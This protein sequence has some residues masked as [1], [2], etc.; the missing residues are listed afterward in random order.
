MTEQEWLAS[1]DPAAMLRWLVGT[2]RRGEP[3]RRHPCVSNRRRRLFVVACAETADISPGTVRVWQEWSE[4]GGTEVDADVA[5]R[6]WSVFHADIAPFRRLR[7][8]EGRARAALLREI[9]GNPWRPVPEF[10]RCIKDETKLIGGNKTVPGHPDSKIRLAAQGI[11]DE[12]RWTDL[13]V[14]ADMLEEAGADNADLLMHLRGKEECPDCAPYNRK[15][16]YRRGCGELATPRWGSW[17]NSGWICLRG[18]HVRGCRAL[19][20]LLG[21]E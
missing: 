14:L 17:C 3:C 13:P 11:Y 2:G 5:D 9:F 15:P 20:L 4:G 10:L 7:E 1:T 21:K 19:D 18:P 12:R 16:D 6:H 8:D